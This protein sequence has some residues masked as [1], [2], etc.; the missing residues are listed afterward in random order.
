MVCVAFLLVQNPW[1]TVRESCGKLWFFDP[2]CIWL[3]SMVLQLQVF[4]KQSDG[5]IT[6]R[7]VEALF[8]AAVISQ[9]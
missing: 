5:F 6:L 1:D 2:S 9:I 3:N 4:L 7:Q 8:E